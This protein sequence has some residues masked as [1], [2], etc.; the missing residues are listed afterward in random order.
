MGRISLAGVGMMFGALCAG[1]CGQ[2]DPNA[3]GAIIDIV[4]GEKVAGTADFTG[5]GIV[6]WKNGRKKSEATFRNGKQHGLTTRWNEAG[7]KIEEYHFSE[8]VPCGR[9]RTW[10]DN[11][12]MESQKFYKGGEWETR[13]VGFG[14]TTL[15]VPHK[16][17][18]W[19]RWHEN[20]QKAGEE[21]YRKNKKHGRFAEWY[22]I[23]QPRW[24]MH[25]KNGKKHGKQTHWD[26]K[27]QL[28]AV[29][30]YE[31]GRFTGRSLDYRD[32]KLIRRN[33]EP[34]Q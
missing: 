33:G 21:N 34:V 10:H 29:R 9:W 18:T 14:S 11:G 13:S 5:V 20:G 16:H 27:G 23:G 6:R 25:Y 17:G 3:G 26:H 19:R 1:G 7:Q 4:E 2:R 24:E 12:V 8:G 28:E 31:G 30:W 22:P 32:G 15:F